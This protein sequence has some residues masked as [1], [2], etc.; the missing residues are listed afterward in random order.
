MMAMVT[1]LIEDRRFGFW[2]LWY[3]KYGMVWYNTLIRSMIHMYI[4]S[5]IQNTTIDSIEEIRLAS[6][7]PMRNMYDNDIRK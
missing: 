2:M 6:P 1:M 5:T 4:Q 7:M 3:G